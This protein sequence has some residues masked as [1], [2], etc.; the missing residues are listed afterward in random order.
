[1][2]EKGRGSGWGW[3]QRREWLYE[4]KRLCG[5]GKS[6]GFKLLGEVGQGTGREER[7][8]GVELASKWQVMR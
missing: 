7:D 3:W 8:G 1:M 2:T 5:I 4:Y 6:L